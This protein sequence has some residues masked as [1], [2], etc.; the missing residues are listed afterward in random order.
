MATAL[1]TANSVDA[2]LRTNWINGEL[3]FVYIGTT[4][5]KT[6]FFSLFFIFLFSTILSYLY[7]FEC[8][9]YP[10]LH[11]HASLPSCV[12]TH[13]CSHLEFFSH[14]FGCKMNDQNYSFFN[15]DYNLC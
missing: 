8:N 9:T 5:E 2:F 4:G 10:V 11:A 12:V 7:L 3:T 1:K 6:T 15:I 13:N 14:F